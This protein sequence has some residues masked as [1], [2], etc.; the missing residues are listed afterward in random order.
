MAVTAGCLAVLAYSAV[1]ANTIDGN[2]VARVLVSSVTLAAVAVIWLARRI[3]K[4]TERSRTVNW[5]MI[6]LIVSAIGALPLP[7][8]S[9]TP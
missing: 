5:L 8:A 1:L 9:G 7:W 3:R 2:A 6:V 4:P